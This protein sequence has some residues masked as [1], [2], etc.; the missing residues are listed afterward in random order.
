MMVPLY[1]IREAAAQVGAPTDKA[2]LRRWLADRG[3]RCTEGRT[4]RGQIGKLYYPET[5]PSDVRAALNLERSPA[6]DASQ[7]PPAVS[8]TRFEDAKAGLKAKANRLLWFMEQ[9]APA[10]ERDGIERAAAELAKQPGAPS[11]AT[12]KR[13]WK[14][15]RGLPWHDWR[16]MLVPAY[17]GR[18]AEPIRAAAWDFFKGFYGR[19][20]ECGAEGVAPPPTPVCPPP[21][22]GTRNGQ[23][24]R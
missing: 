6:R 8:F 11:A 7:S 1:I 24:P 12:L 10:V 5:L 2:C 16:A 19:E 13:H 9:L 18:E 15:I 20:S 17:R 23:E 14:A 21:R 4:R 22:K 3:A